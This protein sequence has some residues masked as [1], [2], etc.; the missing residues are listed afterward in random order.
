MALGRR[1]AA[2]ESA[3]PLGSKSKEIK[4]TRARMRA[5]LA[6]EW[7]ANGWE[8]DLQIGGLILD[9]IGAAGNVDAAAI[10]A[11]LPGSYLAR[12][13]TDRDELAEAISRAIGGES[14]DADQAT[15]TSTVIVNGAT[16]NL[17]FHLSDNAQIENSPFN[18]GA[19]TQINVDASGD[20][21][22]LLRAVQ[23]LLAAGLSDNWDEGAAAAIDAAIAERDD[24]GAED[25]KDAVIKAGKVTAAEPSRI[26]NLLEKVAV[27]A[28]TSTL[29]AGI[30]AGLGLLLANPPI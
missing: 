16:Y 11:A 10:A 20:R 7:E 27:G 28:A 1:E 26:R 29:G 3:A 13:G 12:Y 2:A 24:I 17:S 5:R 30:T 6:A 19:G 9:R 14:L 4:M 23:A 15:S 18:V 25:V 21:E 22:E 8:W